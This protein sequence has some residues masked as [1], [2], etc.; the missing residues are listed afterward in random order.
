MNHGIHPICNESYKNPIS[1]TKLKTITQDQ[2]LS[3]SLFKSDYF[4]ENS[5]VVVVVVV[6]VDDVVVAAAEVVPVLLPLSLVG[7]RQP[8]RPSEP[9]RP[10]R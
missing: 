9:P 8:A 5:V 4:H 7:S 1:S 3:Y 2:A 6:V 10:W